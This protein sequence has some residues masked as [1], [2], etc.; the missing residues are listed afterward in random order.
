MTTLL[1]D[2]TTSD[3]PFDKPV[4]EIS[5]DATL[6]DALKLITDHSLSGIPIWVS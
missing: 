3:F 2:Y 4:I 6:F 5:E 1:N